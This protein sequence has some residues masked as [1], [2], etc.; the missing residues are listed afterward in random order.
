MGT[1]ANITRSTAMSLLRKCIFISLAFSLLVFPLC[2]KIGDFRRIDRKGQIKASTSL[3]RTISREWWGYAPTVQPVFCIYSATETN[4]ARIS[5][6]EY[7]GTYSSDIFYYEPIYL[8]YIL[9][10]IVALGIMR[11]VQIDCQNKT[12]MNGEPKSTT[13]GEKARQNCREAKPIHQDKSR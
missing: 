3:N 7:S 5:S 11:W 9:Q 10:I 12:P 4:T 6:H 8:A 13:E 2:W 1:A